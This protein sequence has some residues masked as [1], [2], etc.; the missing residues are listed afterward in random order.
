VPQTTGAVISVHA[1]ESGLGGGVVAVV[2]GC[3][4]DAGVI[5][6]WL[7]YVCCGLYVP[8][9][10]AACPCV[11]GGGAACPCGPDGAYALFP[12]TVGFAASSA[13]LP[14]QAAENTDPRSPPRATIHTPRRSPL[15]MR[16]SIPRKSPEKTSGS[17][18]PCFDSLRQPDAASLQQRN[19]SS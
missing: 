3:P 9:G 7:P 1:G 5:C 13:W 15:P 11:P 10:G 2:P 8:G 17:A 18:L 6:P 16:I 14:P 4:V 19:P 12:W